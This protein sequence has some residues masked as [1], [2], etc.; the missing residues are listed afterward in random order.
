MFWYRRSTN[1]FA[2]VTFWPIAD[3]ATTMGDK[4]KCRTGMQKYRLLF[5][6]AG[7]TI[8]CGPCM[9][10]GQVSSNLSPGWDPSEFQLSE[11]GPCS[12]EL[13]QTAALLRLRD[14]G[15]SREEITRE[16][17]AE[18]SSDLVV[19]SILGD[20]FGI[21]DVSYF[22]YFVYRNITCMRRHKGRTAPAALAPVAP[23]V[24]ACQRKFGAEASDHLISCIQQA[25]PTE[26]R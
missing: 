4:T 1:C 23:Q 19:N 11:D 10:A 14:S 9:G 18:A 7:A 16:L 6:L 12:F 25:L 22:P 13:A 3:A 15:Q 5:V 2:G 20:I 17:P 21:P 26:D 8:A 24:M